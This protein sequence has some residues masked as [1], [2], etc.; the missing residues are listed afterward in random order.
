MTPAR[1]AAE[2]FRHS[3]FLHG[4]AKGKAS[5]DPA[6]AAAATLLRESRFPLLDIGCGI[7]LLAAYLRESGCHQRILGIEPDAAKIRMAA[8]R[9]AGAYPMVEFQAGDAR[10][11]PE[12]AGD[13][14]MFD[15]L[16]YL[17]PAARRSALEQIAS[18]VAP[19]GR[20]LIRTTFRD[21]SWRYHATLLEEAVVR[22]SGWIRGGGCHFP[23][24]DEVAAPFLGPQWE[25]TAKPMW[26][27][28]P[29][30]SYLIEAR[31]LSHFAG[32]ETSP[33]RRPGRPL[34]GLLKG[35][36]Q[37]DAGGSARVN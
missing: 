25:T 34:G 14:V 4:Y 17:E 35:S 24:N 13:I 19:G 32:G 15:V 11:L 31:R 16:H 9:V 8:A 21:K 12:F 20:A 30:N 27:R 33:T 1:R 22:V 2:R 6:Y 28:T 10:A 5:W 3:R 23:T 18:R 36:P 37:R 29:F 26:G 7:G